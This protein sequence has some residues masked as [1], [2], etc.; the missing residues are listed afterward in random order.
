VSTILG[1]AG[2]PNI[3]GSTPHIDGLHPLFFHDSAAALVTNGRVMYAV[4]EER[5]SRMKHTNCF[6]SGAIQA[7]LQQTGTRPEELDYVAYFF[8]EEFCDAEF[9]RVAAELGVSCPAS[10]RSLMIS[11]LNNIL[12]CEFECERIQFV[13]HHAA[14]AA[15]AH[16][17]STFD[18]CLIVVIDGRGERESISVF[19]A[20]EG[21]RELLAA[22]PVTVSPGFFY[23]QVTRLL[24]FGEFDEYKVMGLSSYGDPGRFS[25]LLASIYRPATSNGGLVLDYEALP[26]I[27]C[28]AQMPPLRPAEPIAQAHKDFAAA[29][30][31]LL[32]CICLDLVRL[33]QDRTGLRRLSLIGGVAHNCRMNGRIARSGLFDEIYI[34]PASHD[35]GSAI[36]AAL[37]VNDA[38]DCTRVA[39]TF[40]EVADPIFSPFLGVC[41]GLSG[42]DDQKAALAAWSEVLDWTC[43]SDLHATVAQAIAAGDIV[44]W[45]RGRSEFGPRALGARSILADPRPLENRT[46]INR[47]VKKREPF[48]P[49]APAVCEESAAEYFELPSTRCNLGAMGFTVPVRVSWR[50]QLQ[51][52]T[53]VDGSARLQIVSRQVNEDFW[54]L[55][56]A[57]EA[58]TGLGVLLNT[59]FN[60]SSEPIIDN[61]R[62]AVRTFLT[63]DLDLLVLGPY[64]VRKRQ[65]LN[66]AL[67]TC[68]MELNIGTEFTLQLTGDGCRR[69]AFLR[70]GRLLETSSRL[71]EYI[72]HQ[73]GKWQIAELLEGSAAQTAQE[74]LDE[75][76]RLWEART[77]EIV[78][79]PYQRP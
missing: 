3:L 51:A 73:T 71:T 54:T 34:H 78:P 19:R 48:R 53:H 47:A 16:H 30:Q 72:M 32:E 61:P 43:P 70:R 57:F 18:E 11:N 10:A 27:F 2:G 77:I 62:D 60:H 8:D 50:S 59:S 5:V 12:G 6:P 65:F 1:I 42:S 26:R 66:T 58:Q 14:H 75:I 41:I 29:A 31:A 44:G 64:V 13:R 40:E 33:W 67:K 55:I 7:C 35:A 21:R 20:A 76:F 15:A 25:N 17:G 28:E 63:T 37:D 38:L 4:E 52:V 56:N 69:G 45:A 39:S 74:L 68:R 46:R 49:F 24:G 79:P 9:R 22:Y 36:G 23:R